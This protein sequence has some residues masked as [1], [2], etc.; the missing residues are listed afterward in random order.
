MPI[1]SH[2]PVLLSRLAA[3]AAPFRD[4]ARELPSTPGVYIMRDSLGHTVYVGKAKNLRRRVG[5]YFAPSASSD[6]KVSK[7][8][9]VLSSLHYAETDSELEALL[10]ESRLVKLWLPI[11]NRDLRQPES[12]CFLRVDMREPL[13]V[14]RVVRF[15]AEDGALHIGPLRGP[16]RVAEA[17]DAVNSVY[18]L[19]QC[20]DP[21]QPGSRGR[22]CT[23][24]DLG[25]CLGPCAADIDAD[26]YRGQVQ[27]AWNSLSGRTDDAISRL[28]ARRTELVERFRFEEAYRVQSRVRA[29]EAIGYGRLSAPSGLGGRFVVVAP[30]A[31]PAR[32][33]LLLISHGKLVARFV[34]GRRD[35]PSDAQLSRMIRCLEDTTRDLLPSK[36]SSDD[37]LIVHSYLRRNRL[38]QCLVPCPSDCL[39]SAIRKAVEIVRSGPA[40]G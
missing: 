14:I 33:V 12:T 18:K 40:D 30:S 8:L 29:L 28:I 38:E 16:S 21:H 10:L 26:A 39:I 35:E 13:P 25:R 32:P 20:T 22:G 31:S 11:F 24:R 7:L 5:S 17:L 6:S 3:K 1:E 37:L 23:Y 19:P 36:P 2:S 9:A 34:C 4:A 27:A 15:Q